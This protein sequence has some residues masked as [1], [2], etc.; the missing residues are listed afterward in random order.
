M[1]KRFEIKVLFDKGGTDAKIEIDPNL[2][3]EEQRALSRERVRN[4]IEV[5]REAIP[6]LK[7]KAD[8]MIAGPSRPPSRRPKKA[9]A[10]AAPTK[11]KK[12][13]KKKVKRP[14]RRKA[15]SASK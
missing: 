12:T 1:T 10:P 4:V 5:L 13:A 7:K 15:K 6:G 11:K 3:T 9:R 8:K 2:K 14:T